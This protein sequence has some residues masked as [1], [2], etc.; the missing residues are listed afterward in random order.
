MPTPSGESTRLRHSSTWRRTWLDQAACREEDPDLFFASD[1]VLKNQA[2]W[3]CAR[4]PVREA[5]LRHALTFPEPYGIWGGFD[6]VERRMIA[7]RLRDRRAKAR[8]RA[9]S[10]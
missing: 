2:K 1:T 4:C 3:T 5:C 6:E 9:R 10:A 8:A 7:R